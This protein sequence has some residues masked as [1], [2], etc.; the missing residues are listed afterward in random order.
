M[1]LTPP[2]PEPGGPI[3]RPLRRREDRRLL[4]GTGR[5]LDDIEEPGALHAVFLR[6]PHA[7]ARIVA[8]D[9]GAARAAVPGA[10]AVLTGADIARHATPLRLAP[11]IEGL[12]PVEMPP[13][14]REVARF[15]GDPVALVVAETRAAAEDAAELV[16]VEYEALPAVASIE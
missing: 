3:G 5:F 6:S 7:H 4:T 2:P 12:H 11:P 14:P 10:G 16:Q 8:I 13:L 9:A 15:A 1:E